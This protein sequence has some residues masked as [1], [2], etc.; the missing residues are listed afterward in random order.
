MALT[1]PNQKTTKDI[2]ELRTEGDE[3]TYIVEAHARM[4]KDDDD[5]ARIR[6]LF[7]E[8]QSWWAR[9]KAMLRGGPAGGG[10]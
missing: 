7:A 1:E 9:F 3:Q 4:T 2:T 10:K 5:K 6:A 8:D